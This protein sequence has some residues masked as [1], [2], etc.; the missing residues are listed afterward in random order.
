MDHLT[1][2]EWFALVSGGSHIFVKI[3][4]FCKNQIDFFN[5]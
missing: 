3:A 1:C 5:F 4:D 2:I